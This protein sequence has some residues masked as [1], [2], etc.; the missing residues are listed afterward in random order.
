MLYV[1]DGSRTA[2]NA[3]RFYVDTLKGLAED[4]VLFVTSDEESGERAD[5]EVDYLRL[6]GIPVRVARREQAPNT[7]A[8]D[9][10]AR[11]N[12]DLILIGAYGKHKIKDYLLG[13]TTSH[14]IRRSPIPVLVVY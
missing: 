11:E 8:L 5:E 6:H 14:L 2:E 12:S 13:T 7:S 3:L 4:F 1:F 9:V 10:A